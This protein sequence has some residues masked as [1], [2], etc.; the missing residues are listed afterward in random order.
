MNLALPDFQRGYVWS[1]EQ[2]RSLV[3]TMLLGL[4]IGSIIAWVR[5]DGSE[6]I[7]DGQQR[8]STLLGMQMGN[9]GDV[10]TVYV[11]VGGGTANAVLG[12]GKWRTPVHSLMSLCSDSAGMMV[13]AATG[14]DPVEEGATDTASAFRIMRSRGVEFDEGA[15]RVASD[16]SNMIRGAH[17]PGLVFTRDATRTDVLDAF[18]RI[19]LGGTP[20][21]AA[22]LERLTAQKPGNEGPPKG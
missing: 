12:P 18:Q 22:E 16:A 15:L 11:D 2:A 13:V 5:K 8:I 17:L 1:P 19:N 9:G 14:L 21:G 4:P 3:E 10:P 6:L 20:I 7:I